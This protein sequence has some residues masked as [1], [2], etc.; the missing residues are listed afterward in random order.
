MKLIFTYKRTRINEK[1][2][3]MSTDL[4]EG[5]YIVRLRMGFETEI[6]VLLLSYVLFIINHFNIATMNLKMC[7]YS[8]RVLFDN[9]YSSALDKI[10]RQKR[11]GCCVVADCVVL[12]LVFFFIYHYYKEI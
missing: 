5:G 9:P 2:C 10:Y 12:L 7:H 6:C 8:M 1:K 3:I 4:D 11:G